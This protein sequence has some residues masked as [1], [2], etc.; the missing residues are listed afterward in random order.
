MTIDAVNP[1]EYTINRDRATHQTPPTGGEIAS[2]V[3]KYAAESDRLVGFL[4]DMSYDEIQV[5]TCDAWKQRCSGVPRNSFVLVKLSPRVVGGNDHF[6]RMLILA[7][8]TDAIPTPVKQDIQQTIFQIHKVQAIVDPLT[9]VELQ[10]GALKATILGTYYDD[11][12]D[13]GGFQVAFGNDIDSFYSPHFYEAYVPCDDDLSYLVNFFV[14]DQNPVT[15][16]KLRFTETHSHAGMPDV[17]VNVTAIDFI[18]NRT[19]MFGKTRMGKSNTIKIIADMIVRS[20]Q[21][22][23]QVIFDPSGEYS[24]Y[25]PQDETSLFLLHRERCTRYSLKPRQP[26][27]EIMAEVPAPNPL[28]ANFYEQVA[29]G[30]SLIVSLYDT[31]HPTRP[32]YISPLLAWEAVDP[33]DIEERFPDYG[34]RT[35]YNR[36]LSMYYALL[37]EA[38]FAAPQNFFVELNLR[39]EIRRVLAADANLQ[40]I[41]ATENHEG[42]VEISERQRLAVA[43]R[44][45]ERLYEIHQ[46]QGNNAAL[47]PDS[48]RTGLPYFDQI[49]SM[50]LRMLGDRNISGPRKLTPFNQYH[51]QAGTDILNDIVRDVDAGKTV[52][53]DLSNADEVVARQY[54]D[55][56]SRA[57]LSNQMRKFADNQIGDHSVLFYFEEAHRLFRQDDKDL[58]NVYN[59]LAKEGGKFSIGMVYA[60]QSMTTLSPDLLRNTENFFIAHLNDD[61]EI[62]ELAHKYEFRDVALD[63]QRSK[64]KGYVRMVTLSHRFALPVQIQKFAAPTGSQA[65]S[66]ADGR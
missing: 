60:T 20:G 15:I 53:I 30:H 59:R 47:F 18:A 8:I 41:A 46:S 35:R 24:Y 3:Q 62:K 52:I 31:V 38:G 42:H 44:I 48:T 25:N 65:A 1:V 26:Q 2:I 14:A 5:I 6:T 16:G 23:G 40:R 22:V 56:I 39:R 34:D 55:L 28:R 9:D 49:Q 66:R 19:A 61:R 27:E 12:L 13:E 58:N 51:D 37:N 64:T 21:N 32:D 33:A 10:W 50:L 29:L 63:V 36:T 7:R 54:S 17:P 4:L 57:I 43:A 45:Y 11:R